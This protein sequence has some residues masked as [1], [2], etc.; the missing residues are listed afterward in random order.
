MSADPPAVAPAALSLELAEPVPTEVPV[1]TD[2]VLR[3]RVSGAACDLRGGRIE[4]VAGEEIVATAELMAFRDDFNE[5][6]A[7]AVRA[8]DRVEAFKWSVRFPPQEIGG[9]AYGESALP[10]SSQTRPH[11]TSLAVWAVPSPVRKADRFT[12]TVG[13]KSSGACALAGANI[14]IRD[15]T[16]APVGK[17]TLRD[18]PWP[19]TDALY[20]TQIALA[21]PSREGLQCWSAAF[22]ATDL[23]PP[24]LGSSAEFSFTAVKPPEHH[25]AVTV[26]ESDVAAPVEETQIAL[27]P[28]RAATD[29]TGMAHIEVPAG[30]YDLAVWKSGFAA[31]SRTVEIAADASVQFELIRLPKELT[32]WD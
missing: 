13:A 16:G 19:G 29:K 24:H 1:G 25:V 20:W 2:V 5:T 4:V 30:T 14:E 15:E 27:G 32:V 22:A 21:G 12:I 23:E 31:A 8:P 18:T 6:A 3:V 9:T 28:Y 10:I 11:R 7:F 17:G 26:T